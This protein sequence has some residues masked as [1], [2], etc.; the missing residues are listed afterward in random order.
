[1]RLA[2]D[3]CPDETK[4][5][6][7]TARAFASDSELNSFYNE[8]GYVSI[9]NLIPMPL[10]KDL[11]EDLSSCAQSLSID[12]SEKFDRV[13]ISLNAQDKSRLYQLH[14]ATAKL[15]SLGA[16]TTKIFTNL[17]RVLGDMAKPVMEIDSSY[18][19]G[20]PKDNR[21][22]YDFHQE[23]NYMKGFAQIFNAHYPIFRKS[24]T[25]NGT[26]SILP[27]THKLGTQNFEKN[28]SSNDSYTDLVP[29]NIEKIKSNYEELHL[30]LELGD[31]VIFHKDLIHKS[32]YNKSDL[33]R[34]V[35]I[36]RLTQNVI[37]D[38]INRSPDEL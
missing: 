24:T 1:M 12:G 26:M 33:C 28:R 32:N 14:L 34:P 21:L 13:A 15:T 17:I 27:G 25:H 16:V 31:C 9:K 20:L 38:W 37:G 36:S 3:Q 11:Q 4:K 23:S 30:E 10:L 7:E 35:G 19:L 8:N 29:T 6:V 18:L 5:L 2:S 22:V